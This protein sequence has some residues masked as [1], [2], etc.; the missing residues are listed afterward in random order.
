[1]A[2]VALVASLFLLA[3]S[4]LCS[5]RLY[6]WDGG[7]LIVVGLA[8]LTLSLGRLFY[9]QRRWGR[10]WAALAPA[11]HTRQ[12]LRVGALLLAAGVG[13]LARRQPAEADFTIWFWLWL[14]AVGGFAATLLI[15]WLR[16]W[17]LPELGRGTWGALALLLLAALLVRVVA[18]GR[19]P[20]NF[21]GDEGTQAAL[22]LDLVAQPLGNPFATGWYSV[23][24]FSFLLYGLSMRLGGAT[25]AG[26]R[27]LSA[28]AGTLTVLTTWLLGRAWD[29]Q[30]VGW[31][32]AV[33]L[34]FSAYHIHFSRLASNQIFD[35][36]VATLTFWLLWRALRGEDENAVAAWGLAGMA[37]GCGWYF[38]FGARWVTVLVALFLGWRAW[39]ES[40]FLT[41]HRRGLWT[42]AA[43]WLVVTLP[44]LCWYLA[45]PSPLTERYRAVSIFASGWLRREVEATGKSTALLLLQQLWKAASAFH[46]TPDPTFWYRPEM[47]LLDFVSGALL[48]VGLVATLWRWRW[49]AR[50]GTLLWWGATLIAA[51]GITEN[52]P[53]SQRGLLLLPVVALLIAWGVETLWELLVRYREVGKYLPRALLA[54]ACLLNLGF[55][56]GVYTPRRVYGN[57]SA[58]TATELV[59]FVRAHPRPGSTIYFY[60]APYLYWDFGV[61]KFLLRDQAGVDVPP[62]EIS[63][64]VESPARFILVSERQVELGAVMQR[65]PGG[66]LH[67]IRDPVGD[68]VL[69]V[70]YDW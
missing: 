63:P 35:P 2:G 64:D 37:A 54:V 45:H 18:L 42:L 22:S 39:V 16:D 19:I 24:T 65:Y 14:L 9:P 55:Y 8:G 44:L 33:M 69:A 52:P 53:S 29:G 58:K 32:A 61:L 21:G 34:A 6:P 31:V 13:W 30:R 46:F 12:G 38:Y 27:L 5:F 25:V 67:E 41:R 4:Y 62:E 66:E 70:I 49:P 28:L 23:P 59:H 50:G 36:L 48:L 17:R 26:A 51:W 11:A 7:L 40:R 47:P 43:G 10:G 56:F 15:P 57:P 20:A 3:G 60:G 1:M 68:G